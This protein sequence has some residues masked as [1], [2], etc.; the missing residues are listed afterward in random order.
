MKA[1]NAA[2]VRESL[3]KPHLVGLKGLVKHLGWLSSLS[4]ILEISVGN[5]ER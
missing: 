1:T 3:G 5:L 4:N 2:R